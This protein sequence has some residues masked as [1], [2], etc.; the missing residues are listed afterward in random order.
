MGLK[1]KFI[2]G[3]LITVLLLSLLLIVA[4]YKRL[5]TIDVN[6]NQRVDQIYQDT[7][8]NIE[9]IKQHQTQVI[10]RTVIVREAVRQEVDALTPDELV[11]F[12]IEEIRLFRDRTG[13]NP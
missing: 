9:E 13:N 8:E 3:L 12:A 2:I 10:E 1:Y 5:A 7:E 4:K 6:V 11:S